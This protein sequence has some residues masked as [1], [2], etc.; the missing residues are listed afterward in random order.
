MK[1]K[2]FKGK[3]PNMD[4]VEE[5]FPSGGID[6]DF[7][8]VDGEVKGWNQYSN[9]WEKP[10]V[11]PS[12]SSRDTKTIYGDLNVHHNVSIGGTLSAQLIRGKNS[13][14]GVFDSDDSLRRHHP[15]P[16]PGEWAMVFA[17]TAPPPTPEQTSGTGVETVEQNSEPS[18]QS[19]E[20]PVSSEPVAETSE[21]PIERDVRDITIGFIFIEN[22]GQWDYSGY[23]G[24][25]DGTFEALQKEKEDRISDVEDLYSAIQGERDRAKSAEEALL[26]DVEDDKPTSIAKETEMREQEDQDIRETVNEKE[27]NLY[28]TI[29]A[30]E[31][32]GI[33]I[34][35]GFGDS[36]YFGISQKVLTESR[37]N[38][39]NQ[40]NAIVN[41][42]A[43][44]NLTVTPSHVFVGEVSDIS[45]VASTNTEATSIKIKK[46]DT[47]LATGEG[48]S[49]NGSDTIT[50]TETGITTYMAEFIIAGL[51]KQATKNVVAVYPIMYGTGQEYE[52]ATEEATPRSTPAGT[53]NITVADD[54]D[55]VFFVVPRTMNIASAKMNG[56]DF[57]LSEAVDITIGEDEEEVEYK[58][59]QSANTYDADTVLTIVIS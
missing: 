26:G 45:L 44:V 51:Q 24:G 15:N 11:E 12:S 7:I 21:T 8:L 33:E 59:Y 6:G 25:Y 29:H 28:E 1:L 42:K 55:Y 20:E 13:F 17:Y 10:T 2:E 35:Q 48:M 53:Y 30:L 43:Q 40:I 3:F 4:A 58:Y 27:E 23:K 5:A 36:P 47:E 50:P 41:D 16:V 57:P 19:N 22:D 37:D 32:S 39:Q 38:L 18:E 46:G 56:F 49:L 31:V 54:G 52:D 14:C 34:K 9:K